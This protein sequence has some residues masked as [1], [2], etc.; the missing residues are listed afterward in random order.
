MK[1]RGRP[2]RYRRS[3]ALVWYWSRSGLTCFDPRHRRRTALPPAIVATLDRLSDWTTAAKLRKGAPELGA[4]ASVERLLRTLWQSGL[5]DR[6]PDTPWKW[7]HWSPE[8]AFFH[9]G[10]RDAS[11]PLDRPAHESALT[12][13]AKTDPPPPATK[14]VEGRRLPLPSPVVGGELAQTLLERRTW[15]HFGSAAIDVAQLST[16]LQLTWGVQKW[17]IVKGQG[18]VALKTSPSGGARHSIEAYVLAL[19]VRGLRRGAYHYD[20]ARHELVDLGRR[21]SPAIVTRLVANQKYFGRAAVTIVM[22]AVFARAMWR[23]P[24]SRAYRS[25]LTEAGHLGQTFCL[26]ATAQNLA[27]FCTMAFSERHIEGLVG[28]DPAEEGAVYVVGVGTRGRPGTA[29]PGRIPRGDL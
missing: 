21:I 18:R 5:L 17:G 3:P 8:A 13:K 6:H 15:R 23:Y 1:T 29:L 27:P 10:T 7:D 26:L 2:A 19:D 24:F 9:F 25:L 4:E 28:L 22:T 11:Y 20:A 14:T 16:I 12:R